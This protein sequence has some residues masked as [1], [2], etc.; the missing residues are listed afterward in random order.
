MIYKYRLKILFGVQNL[1][2]ANIRHPDEKI[3]SCARYLIPSVHEW[4]ICSPSVQLSWFNFD[5]S[6][7]TSLKFVRR[8]F[9][10]NDHIIYVVQDGAQY[11]TWHQR[12]SFSRF[13]SIYLLR[14]I[15]VT[16][17][18]S[19]HSSR[20][21]NI[22]KTSRSFSPAPTILCTIGTGV[23]S[24]GMSLSLLSVCIQL[25]YRKIYSGK[26]MKPGTLYNLFASYLFVWKSLKK[27]SWFA[28]FY[29]L[30]SWKI[31]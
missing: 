23:L 1:V 16:L 7:A 11:F 19:T 25:R 9:G 13:V 27:V 24:R 30:F 26:E 3:L 8:L 20:K 6:T 17:C 5:W 2:R 21:Q 18:S 31:I 14:F 28:D 12:T 15:E 22:S 10:V 29:T 4:L